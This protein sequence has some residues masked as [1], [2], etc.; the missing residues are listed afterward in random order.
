MAARR[1]VVVVTGKFRQ[2][3]AGDTL[4]GVPAKVMVILNG[5]TT[6]FINLSVNSTLPLLL[7]GG[8]SYNLPVTVNG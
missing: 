4:L 6:S 5:G 1:P 2:L 8:T 7:N 3:P